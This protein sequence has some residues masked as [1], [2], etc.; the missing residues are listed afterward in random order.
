MLL[1]PVCDIDKQIYI[2][3]RIKTTLLEMLNMFNKRIKNILMLLC[4]SFVI[5]GCAA[6]GVTTLKSYSQKPA[7]SSLDIFSSIEEIH[8][9]YEIIC[10]IDSK[11]GNSLFNDKTVAGAINL[12]KPKALECGA[13]AILVENMQT[14]S[15]NGFNY[16]HASAI[17]KA[18][19]Y[20]Q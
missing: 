2:M 15:G 19:K 5:T 1:E 13:D 11:T 10:L 7:D 9:P 3:Y 16:G 12:A 6:V 18:I 4:F 20:L 8:K 14:V 17:I